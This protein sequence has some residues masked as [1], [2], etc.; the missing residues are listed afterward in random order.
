MLIDNT[1]Q[2]SVVI[3]TKELIGIKG[4]DFRV[5]T[6]I[7]T[8]SNVENNTLV[9]KNKRYVSLG[10]VDKNMD[11]L[12]EAVG[13]SQSQFRKHLRALVKHNSNEFK[14]VEKEFNGKNIRCYEME[15]NKGGFV[16]I[17][18]DKVESLLTGGSNNCIKLYA[19]LL[20]LC[21]SDGEFVERELTQNY[22]AK[23]M[24]LS[25]NMDRVVR[26]ATKWL[27]GA[28]LIQT[29]KIWENETIIDENGLPKGS[30]PKNKIFYSIII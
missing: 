18:I 22:L 9:G 8:I 1:N 19:N 26:I 27:E 5:I 3:P 4:T 6:A 16:N 21:N 11:E 17:P 28:G 2:S 10:K 14:I 15:Y 23:T 7:S 29:R 12:C 30:K 25:P 24:G 13:I 20:W